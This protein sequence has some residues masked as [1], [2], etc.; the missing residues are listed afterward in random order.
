[1]NSTRKRILL[2]LVVL[3]AVGSVAGFGAYSSFT[4]T[5]TNTGNSIAAGTV[6]IG[7]HAGAATLY[8]LTN[9]APG[10]S[11]SKCIRV[12]YT[13]TLA[14]S[15]KLYVSAGITNPTAFNL[16]VERGSG[17]TTLDNTMSCAGFSS[18]STAYATAAIGS[19][20]TSYAAGVDGK[21]GGAA[22]AQND[23][24]DYRFTISVVDDATPNA[25]TS[26]L[27][28]LAHTYTWEARSN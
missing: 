20:G 16:Q 4:A 28:T 15:V 14:S 3:G 18:S 21:A 22:W 9:Q 13:G 5:T 12:T 24:V 11:T 2:T 27:S 25:H 26:A 1:L 8:S 10:A 19:F 23:S 7:Q 17:L 6:E